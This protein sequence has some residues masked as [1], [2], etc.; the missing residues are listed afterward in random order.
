[1]IY[2][3]GVSP[4]PKPGA[5]R[6]PA[7]PGNRALGDGAK[8]PSTRAAIANARFMGR[9]P[10]T[11]KAGAM[12]H[13]ETTIDQFTRQ[14][15]GFSSAAAMND[16][17]AMALLLAAARLDR[18]DA[19]L[20]V[21]CGPGIVTAAV[22]AEAGAVVGI[23]LTP[24]M[25]E[26]ARGRCAGQGLDN[27]RFD[28]GDVTELPY[29]DGE[30]SRVVCRYALHHVTDPAAV[31]REMARVC[32]PGG[33]VVVADMIVADD[34]EA[35]ARFNAAERARD[36][37]HVRSMPERELLG[38]LRDAGLRAEPVGAYALPMELDALLARS[39]S[40]DPD[41]VRAIYAAAIDD[42]QG[43]GIGERRQG[44]RVRFEFP[45]SLVAGDREP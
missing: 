36:P 43:L 31:V 1:M 7:C 38:L 27:V 8:T 34:A 20:D 16:A 30:F 28:L 13:E 6:A 42:G 33:R 10:D 37:S 29:A 3:A 22:A 15:A 12:D 25:L 23:D 24:E 4:S 11:C 18:G 5:S 39:A 2:A 17:D 26:L 40:P 9:G 44:D 19:V 21:A 45:I 41:G 35:A 14:A 32:A